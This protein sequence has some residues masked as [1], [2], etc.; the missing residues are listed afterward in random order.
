MDELSLD[1]M[2]RL[3]PKVHEWGGRFGHYYGNVDCLTVELFGRV[4]FFSPSKIKK[5]QIIVK[6]DSTYIGVSSMSDNP[7]IL[8]AYDYARKKTI[9]K[10]Q[11]D[12]QRRWEQGLKAAEDLLKNG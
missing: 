2:L 4:G 3:V 7:D 6:N 1:D 10:S 12:E 9:E 8:E 11:K 5:A